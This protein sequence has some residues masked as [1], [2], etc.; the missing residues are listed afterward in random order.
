MN[1]QNWQLKI[2]PTDSI[3]KQVF[4]SVLFKETFTSKSDMLAEI[5]I[6]LNQLEQKGIFTPQLE[7]LNSSNQV[8]IYNITIGKIFDKI[9]L[10]FDE[11][12]SETFLSVY[13]YHQE[14]HSIT[15]PIEQ[16][17]G[18]IKSAIAHFEENGS[19]FVTIKIINQ[20]IENNWL[21]AFVQINLTQ[22]RTID[23]IIVEGYIDFPLSFLKHQTPLKMGA[24]FN[25][26]KINNASTA[27]QKLSFVIFSMFYLTNIKFTEFFKMDY[28]QS[29]LTMNL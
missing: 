13:Q 19:P 10:Y 8:Y 26:Q 16:T 20:K 2:N 22:K 24:T 15:I 7:L 12:L 6:I 21:S 5:D 17:A 29:I 27:I 14:N 23:K 28:G 11:N 25:Q 3:S 18:F 4:K 9:T 1:A